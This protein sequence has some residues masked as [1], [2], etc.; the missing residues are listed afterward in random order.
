LDGSL[1]KNYPARLSEWCCS[2]SMVREEQKC[3][4]AEPPNTFL[5]ED[6]PMTILSKFGSRHED[7]DVNFP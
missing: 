7:F 2:V 6:H 3:D 1:P 5:E 4:R